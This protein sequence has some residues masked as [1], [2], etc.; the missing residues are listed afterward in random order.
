[1]IHPEYKYVNVAVEGVHN[2][3]GIYDINN[4]GNPSGKPE[5]YCTYFR[6]NDE[7]K[8]HFGQKGTVS[9]YQGKAW[10]DWL[11]I[12]IDSE[13]LEDAQ[14]YLNYLIS[15]LDDNGIDTNTCRFYFSGAKGFHVMIPTAYLQAEPSVD[16]HKRFRK[17]AIHL[18]NGINIDTS[19]YDKTRIFRLPNTINTKT[20]LHKI[21]LY[22]FEAMSLDIPKILDQARE[23]SE[24]LDIEKDL[25]ASND[26]ADLFHEDL[27]K[28]KTNS[29]KSNAKTKICME[30]LMK[31]RSQGDRDDVGV[32]VASHLRQSGLTM[33][34][35]W[36]A[37]NEWNDTNDPPLD[38]DELERIY[39]QGLGQ[40]EFGCHDPFL[41]A[42]CDPT[43]LFYKKSWGRF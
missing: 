15:N 37:L 14:S 9:G 31:G 4:L 41:K 30:T 32:R 34:M 3:K 43:C 20:G 16:I 35:I 22:S 24:K 42:N 7:M 19:I 39:Q 25:D 8:D 29:N 40:Y 27:N 10:S 5:T 23:P 11:P 1:M 17:I 21:E 26:L 18:A 2:R 12:D 28:P 38:T 33:K 13:N 6:Y 36:V